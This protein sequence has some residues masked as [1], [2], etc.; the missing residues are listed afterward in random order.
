MSLKLENTVYHW[1]KILR[2]PVASTFVKEKLLSHSDYPSLVSVTD[3]LD[4][5]AIENASI[6]VDKE[7]VNELPVP[8]LAHTPGSKGGLIIVTNVKQL[9]ESRPSFLTEWDGVALM[10]EKPGV[11]K[12]A[13]N[14]KW[15]AMEQ[16]K[17]QVIGITAMG[18]IS[19]AAFAVAINFSWIMIVLL[20][21][22][23]VGI[24]IAIL[25]A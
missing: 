7:R 18:F 13:E 10:A 24:G 6:V 2:I 25:I 20:I 12:N 19:L 9:L 5:L 15:L 17:K 14:D 16:K 22:T 11:F 23:L 21:T 8:F 3:L 4:E 1:L